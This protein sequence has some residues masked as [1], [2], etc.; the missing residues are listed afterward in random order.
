MISAAKLAKMGDVAFVGLGAMGKGMAAN[1]ASSG[2]RVLV[3]NRTASVAEAHA[4]AHGTTAVAQLAELRPASI[5]VCCLPTSAH[6]AEVA[7]QLELQPGSVL[8]DCTSG[9]PSQTREIGA[10]LKERGIELVDCPVSGG[11]AGAE[12][13]QLTAMVT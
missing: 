13:G 3:Y 9:D 1:L 11:P 4:A 8:V 12:S 7:R 10:E 2:G 6:V 5:V